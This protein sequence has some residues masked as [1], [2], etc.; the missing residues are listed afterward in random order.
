MS[1][2]EIA[3][4]FDLY[5]RK[6]AG[7][8]PCVS[9]EGAVALA[10]QGRL[11]RVDTGSDGEDCLLDGASGEDCLA[12][13]AAFLERDEMPADWRAERITLE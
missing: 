12:E 7:C 11:W 8:V 4:L 1:I 2:E 10:H 13:L 9:A 3:R 6:S 5:A